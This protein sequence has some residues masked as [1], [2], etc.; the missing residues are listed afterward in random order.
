MDVAID[1]GYIS[2]PEPIEFP[3]SNNLTAFALYY[4]PKSKDYVGMPNERPPLLVFSHGGPTSAANSAFKLAIQYWTSRG[5]AVVDVNYGG[6]VG[7]GRAYRERLNGNW[8]VVDMDDCI[9][10]ARFLEKRGDV[11][12]KRMAIRGGSA[13]GYTTLCSLVFSNV[14]RAG[15]SYYGVAD[16]AALVHDTH[17]FESRYLDNLIGPYPE[18]AELY[19]KRSPIHFADR[20]SCPVIL[21]Q[22]L[23]DKVVPPSQA[24]IMI[25][26]LRAKRLPFAY[27]S[28]PTEAHGFREAANIQRAAEAELYFYGRIFRF[29]PEEH[30]DP[31]PIENV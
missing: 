3:T 4:P 19:R 8:G 27:V 24:E 5:F 11:D 9:N 15:A 2:E 17:K 10:A 13:G 6:S 12:G 31:V 28:F 23:E 26:A 18:A 20:L 14:F 29:Q 25:E 16:L 7:Y 1:T 22:G 21:F 30:I